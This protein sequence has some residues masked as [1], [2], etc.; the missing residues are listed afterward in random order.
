MSGTSERPELSIVIPLFNE[1]ANVEALHSRLS[2]TLQSLGKSFEIVYVDDGSADGTADILRRIHARAPEIKAVIFNRN[3]GQHA[4]VLA[5]FERARGEVV[6]TLD[7]DLQNPPEEIPKLL[8]K[9]DEGYDVVGGRREERR[10]PMLRRVFSFLINR[11]VSRTVGVEMKDY[12][13]ML[14]AYRR[15]IVERICECPEISTFIPALANSFAGSVAEIPIAHSLRRSGKSRYTPLRLLRL[16]F[17]LLT[18]FSLLPIQMAGLAGILIAFFGLAL[19]LFLGASIIIVGAEGM[20]V[21]MLFAVLFFFIGLQILA[22]GLVG[23]YVGRI[24]M[25]VRRRPKYVVKEI[26]D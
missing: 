26:L 21:L 6:V 10:D 22:L 15:G 19:A 17:D 24:Y 13:C 9:I 20:G 14:R 12:G 2:A 7:G 4:A 25:E 8:E 3:Y 16:T 23:E 18:G 11:L 5:G 1:S